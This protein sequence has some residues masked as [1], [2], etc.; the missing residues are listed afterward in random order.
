MEFPS[1][2]NGP[3]TAWYQAAS[4]GEI[5]GF[6]LR[7]ATADPTSNY[8]YQGLEITSHKGSIGTTGGYAGAYVVNGV[9]KNTGDQSATKLTVVAA[10]F[11][12]TGAVVGVGFT[13][14]LDPSVLVPDNTTTFQVAALDLN[15]SVVPAAL[16]IKSYQLLVQTSGP[17]LQGTAPI[18]SPQP[19]G[20]TGPTEK[21]TTH[22][23]SS[24]KSNLSDIFP[25]AIAIV[26]AVVVLVAVVAVVKQVMNRNAR[27]RQ[28]LKQARK[29]KKQDP[30]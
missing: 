13:N 2:H 19:T 6:S 9:I 17:I 7:V 23:S 4:D 15:Q 29:A 21:S 18:A 24:P 11:N 12:S 10:F 8:Q 27:N 16:Q 30:D 20:T 14:Y 28:N 1:P 22:S 5:S 25:I 3:D 26:I